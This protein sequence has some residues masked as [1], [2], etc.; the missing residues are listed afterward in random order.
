MTYREA[1]EV[2]AAAGGEFADPSD[3]FGDLVGIH[4]CTVPSVAEFDGATNRAA[5]DASDPN[6]DVASG[7]TRAEAHAL[8]IEKLAMK[9]RNGGRPRRAHQL[10]GLVGVGAALFKRYAECA[11]LGF[12][13]STGDSRDDASRRQPVEGCEFLCEM[14]RVAIRHDDHAGRELDSSGDGGDVGERRDR[15]Q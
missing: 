15:F 11:K 3:A 2:A 10:D 5:A 12:E 14:N 9:F 6:R 8:E 7:R 4:P 13:P 1:V